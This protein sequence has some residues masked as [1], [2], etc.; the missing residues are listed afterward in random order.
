MAIFISTLIA[1]LLLRGIYNLAQ[2]SGILVGASIVS[3]LGVWDDRFSLG[4]FGKLLGQL[5]AVGLLLATGVRVSLFPYAIMDY[6][7]TI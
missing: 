6:A 4:V 2:L 7:V 1:A 3:I 5:L